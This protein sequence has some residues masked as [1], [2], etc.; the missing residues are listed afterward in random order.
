MP[1]AIV[2]IWYTYGVMRDWKGRE[3]SLTWLWLLT[4]TQKS[5]ND[6]TLSISG[7]SDIEES[8]YAQQV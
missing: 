3:L 1:K 4:G 6:E 8:P 7:G 5:L 2:V